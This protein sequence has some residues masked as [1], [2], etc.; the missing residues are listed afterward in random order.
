[1]LTYQGHVLSVFKDGHVSEYRNVTI[2]G[3]VTLN[4]TIYPICDVNGDG[5]V[6][7]KDVLKLRRA[8]AGLEPLY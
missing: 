1:M 3:D 8:I 4:V 2:D 5:D 6:N 7:M